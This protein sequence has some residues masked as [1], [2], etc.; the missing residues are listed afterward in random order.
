[1][2]RRRRRRRRWHFQ[3]VHIDCNLKHIRFIIPVSPVYSTMNTL[4]RIH[5]YARTN[6]RV[7]YPR[8]IVN[9]LDALYKQLILGV[10]SHPSSTNLISIIISSRYAYAFIHT[11]TVRALWKNSICRE[12]HKAETR[13][14]LYVCERVRT[15]AVVTRVRE[16]YADDNITSPR[17]EKYEG[18]EPKRFSSIRIRSTRY[19]NI[20]I[21]KPVVFQSML[22]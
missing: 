20:G 10:V 17:D 19:G 22:G 5:T 6:T 4:S 18:R 12:S 11:Y 13:H 21:V 15:V 14:A 16:R 8:R 3:T 9:P 2:H 7:Y 1:M